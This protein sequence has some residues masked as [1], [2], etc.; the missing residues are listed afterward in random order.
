MTLLDQAAQLER[1]GRLDEAA[2]LCF[3]ATRSAPHDTAAWQALG[4][5]LLRLGRWPEAAAS[6]EAALELGPVDADSLANY[7]VAL[8]EQRALERA[9]EIYRRALAAAPDH[10]TAHYNLGNALRELRRYDDAAASY[11]RALAAQPDWIPPLV[12]LG[13]AHAAAGRVEGA[14]ASYSRVLALNPN[15]AQAHNGMGLAHQVRGEFDLA[16][17]HFDRAIAAAP[18]EPNAHSNRAQLWLLQGDFTRGWPEYEWRLRVP[19]HGIPATGAQR[20]DGA[21]LA[22]RTILLRAEQGLGDTVMLVRFATVL[23]GY[24]A[25]VVLET[26]PAIERL[27][28][29]CPGLAGVISRGTQLPPHDFES[30]IASVPLHLRVTAESIPA[31]VPYL[32]ADTDLVEA[33]RGRIYPHG[34]SDGVLT[35]GIAWQGNPAFPQDCH[36]SFPLREFAPLAKIPGVRL[37]SLQK[38]YGAEQLAAAQ[39]PIED[40]G[41][42]LDPGGGAFTDTAAAMMGLDLVVASDS[43]VVHVAGALGRPV[44]V[45]LPVAPDWRW[46]LGRDDTPWYPTMRLYRQ[47]QLGNWTEVFERIARALAMEVARRT[48]GRSR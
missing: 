41:A 26:Q 29:T 48:S 37:F 20:W 13:L 16:L 44:W 3:E 38:G 7:G 18:G 25:R 19:G 11:A 39:F 12:N 40:L 17:A 9:V 15:H 14:I 35:V 4:R 46:L 24:G 10:A 33:A 23:A 34:R 36:R 22:G 45:A 30:P 21:A 1:D 28:A 47:R 32:S 43:A 6:Y 8:A 27:V 42:A 2:A 31:S 5:I